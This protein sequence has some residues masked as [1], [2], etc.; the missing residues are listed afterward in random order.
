MKSLSLAVLLLLGQ[1][2]AA[3]HHH[4]QN[5][6]TPQR[7]KDISDKSIDPWVY[8]KVY[9]NVNPVNMPRRDTEPVPGTYTPHGN[10]YWPSTKEQA[11]AIAKEKAEDDLP[12]DQLPAEIAGVNMVQKGKRAKWQ[13]Y[14]M[15]QYQNEP[16]YDPAKDSRRMKMKQPRKDVSDKSIDPYVF[17]KVYESVEPQPWRRPEKAPA[18]NTYTPPVSLIQKEQLLRNPLHNFIQ[19]GFI[20]DSD[21]IMENTN[22]QAMADMEADPDTVSKASPVEA[23]K[24]KGYFSEFDGSYHNGQGVRYFPNGKKI[25]GV[26]N[27]LALKKREPTSTAGAEEVFGDAPPASTAGAEEVFGDAPPKAQGEGQAQAAA[28]SQG[29]AQG[30][31]ASQGEGQAQASA[32]SQGQA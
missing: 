26:N 28:P 3:K 31:G 7:R 9:D 21:S 30:A 6:F 1:D 27:W 23:E 22:I 2:A 17:E 25:E 16:Q 18:R 19:T 10:P 13:R 4:H 20:S 29:Q 14:L 12:L 32:P 11:D 15:A 24:P 8:D 5:H